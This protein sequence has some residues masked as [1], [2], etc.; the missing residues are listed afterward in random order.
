MA[1]APRRAAFEVIDT[2][3]DPVAAPPKRDT[4]LLLLALKT[5]SQRALAAIA[6]LFTLATVGLAFWLFFAIKDAP[7][8]L[9]LCLAAMCALFMLAI[10]WIVRRG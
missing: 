10:N 8:V 1:D 5:L 6:D 4:G 7:N 3:D 9:Q 2:D